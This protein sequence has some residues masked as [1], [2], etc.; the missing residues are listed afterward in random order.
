MCAGKKEVTLDLSGL[1]TLE[2]PSCGKKSTPF[3]EQHKGFRIAD[4][5]CKVI[6]DNRG[7][8]VVCKCGTSLFNID[9]LDES[10]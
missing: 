7:F 2:C 5:N 6:I 8:E 4:E 1:G 3:L 10:P 9:S